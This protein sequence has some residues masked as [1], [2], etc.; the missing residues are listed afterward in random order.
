M[1]ELQIWDGIEDDGTSPISANSKTK[2][3]EN[4]F[5]ENMLK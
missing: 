1:V 5:T 2:S 4:N 3:K